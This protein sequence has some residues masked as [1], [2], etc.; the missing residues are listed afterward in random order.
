[1]K[2]Y[3]GEKSPIS[4]IETKQTIVSNRN[5]GIAAVVPSYLLQEILY[6]AELIIQRKTEQ[7]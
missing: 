1:M 5:V 7:K 6:S 4:V 3:F 2:G